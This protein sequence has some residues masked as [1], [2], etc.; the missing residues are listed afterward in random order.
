VVVGTNGYVALS[1]GSPLA[2]NAFN[3]NSNASLRGVWQAPGGSTNVFAVGLAQTGGGPG[4]I[5]HCSG[6]PFVCVSETAP[7][8]GDLHAISGRSVNGQLDIYAVGNLGNQVLHS[9]GNGT[10]TAVQVP[11]NSGMTGVYVVP[12]GEVYA[13]GSPSSGGAQITQINHLY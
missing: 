9:T 12:N 10:W 5:L 2:L 1:G 6:A 4:S 11:S 13:V 3:S 8:N 7:I